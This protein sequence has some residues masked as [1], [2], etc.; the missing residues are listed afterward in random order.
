M[1]DLITHRTPVGK[2]SLSTCVAM[3][4]PHAT[5][6]SIA[7]R[8]TLLQASAVSSTP[9]STARALSRALDWLDGRDRRSLLEVL[10]C[11]SH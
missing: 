4:E 11:A 3:F 10:L 1:C 9:T 7:P 6:L 5:T 2:F 8:S